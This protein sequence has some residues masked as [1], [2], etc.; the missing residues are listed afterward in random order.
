MQAIRT[1]GGHRR[2]LVNDVR[3]LR[4]TE[5]PGVARVRRV[6]PPGRALPLTAAFLRERTTAIVHAGLEATYEAPSG[7]WF[8][9]NE[10]RLHV[11]NWLRALADAFEHG[12]YDAAIEA[13]VQ[14]SGRA[15]IGAMAVERVTF[16]DR[17][18]AAL[19]RLLSENAET[20]DELPAARRVCAA[21]RHCALEGIG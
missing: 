11:E 13:T 7:G 18:C 2:F 6:Q 20:R 9:G 16:V 1:K 21:L 10:G 3:R 15:R 14:L 17:S 4:S 8:A 12:Q 5:A 19:L